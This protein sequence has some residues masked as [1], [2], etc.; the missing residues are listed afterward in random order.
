MEKYTLN[1]T[2]R[3]VQEYENIILYK[4]AHGTYQA[5]IDKLFN[6]SS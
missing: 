5:N 6:Y 2:E 1:I 4:E 3:F